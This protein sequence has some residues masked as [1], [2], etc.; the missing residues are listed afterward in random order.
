MVE[1]QLLRRGVHDSRILGALRTVPRHLFVPPGLAEH[2]YADRPVS[3][4]SGQTISQPYVVACMTEALGLAG[5]ERVLEIGTGSGY[6]TAVLAELAA[7]V[8]SIE[9]LSELHASARQRLEGLG[10]RNVRL[11]FGDGYAGWPE[12]APFDS[13][14]VTAAPAGVPHALVEQL[15]AKGRMVLPLGTVRQTLTCVEKTETGVCE[16]R[17]FPVRFVPMVGDHRP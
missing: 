16:R 2:A 11:R 5:T 10:Y 6:Q 12:E 4:G 17:L 13:I 9:L 14:L 8:F 3:I 15:D 1:E 7:E